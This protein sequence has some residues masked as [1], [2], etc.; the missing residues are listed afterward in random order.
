[1]TVLH[2]WTKITTRIILL[3]G[4]SKNQNS[5][6]HLVNE[7]VVNKTKTD[8]QHLQAFSHKGNAVIFIKN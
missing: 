4:K 8:E 7:N 6:L 3:R 2:N 5:K 1:M